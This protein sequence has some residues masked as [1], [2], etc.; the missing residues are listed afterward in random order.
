MNLSPQFSLFKCPWICLDLYKW[1]TL[2]IL[3]IHPR[4]DDGRKA[5]V[6]STLSSSFSFR[7]VRFNT[8]DYGDTSWWQFSF[9]SN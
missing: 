5:R 2:T 8:R 9:Y 7:A 4:D 6:T 1:A 3:I